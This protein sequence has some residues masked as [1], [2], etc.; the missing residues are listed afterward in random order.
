MSELSNKLCLSSSSIRLTLYLY[1]QLNPTNNWNLKLR[2]LPK[3]YLQRHACWVPFCWQWAD[4]F[5][6]NLILWAWAACRSDGTASSHCGNYTAHRYCSQENLRLALLSRL[7]GKKVCGIYY[8]DLWKRLS[9]ASRSL[10]T[11]CRKNRERLGVEP[12]SR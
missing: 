3:H 4:C 9:S 10:S 8:A 5:T 1:T 6:A 7:P 2:L 11:C 12:S